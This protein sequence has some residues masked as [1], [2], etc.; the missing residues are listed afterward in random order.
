MVSTNSVKLCY[1]QLVAPHRLYEN[2]PHRKVTVTSQ[3]PVTSGS[4]SGTSWQSSV[5]INGL[6]GGFGL[7]G[8]RGASSSRFSGPSAVSG[9]TPV[10]ITTQSWLNLLLSKGC[11]RNREGAWVVS[12]VG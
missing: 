7:L 6:S 5:C 10:S 12:Y 2:T 3:V 1:S 8:K 9:L 4:A 11:K